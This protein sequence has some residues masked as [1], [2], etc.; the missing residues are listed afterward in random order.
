MAV[1][2]RGGNALNYRGDVLLL[3]HTSDIKPLSGTLALLDWRC[4]AA[5][6]IL[7]KR[8]PDLFKFGQLT[9]LATQGKVPTQTVVLTGLGTGKGLGRDMRKE[10]YSLAL[11]AAV[12]LGGRKVAVEGIPLAGHHDKGVLDDLVVTARPFE[13]NGQLTVSLFS[14]D[15]DFTR[16]LRNGDGS[17]ASS[18]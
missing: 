14:T 17:R 10:A 16:S 9:V 3:F 7:W 15:K 5:V 13:K 8:K 2:I 1:Q 12:K 6:S 4:N 11:D 18:G